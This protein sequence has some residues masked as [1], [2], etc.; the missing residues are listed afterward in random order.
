MLFRSLARRPGLTELFDALAAA[1]QHDPERSE[2]VDGAAGGGGGGT[3]ES[4]G[5]HPDYPERGTRCCQTGLLK[6]HLLYPNLFASL[7]KGKEKSPIREAIE[8]FK[9]PDDFESFSSMKK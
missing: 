8:L 2:G 9:I 6:H 4:G 1:C 7:S 5:R 3:A